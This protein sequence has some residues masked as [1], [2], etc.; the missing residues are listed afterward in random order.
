MP[1]EVVGA[2][3]SE[4]LGAVQDLTTFLSSTQRFGPSLRNLLLTSGVQVPA[5]YG[6]QTPEQLQ[7]VVRDVTAESAEEALEQHEAQESARIQ[8]AA[9]RLLG[10]GVPAAEVARRVAA[11]KERLLSTQARRAASELKKTGSVSRQTRA[12]LDAAKRAYPVANAAVQRAVKVRSVAPVKKVTKKTTKKSKPVPAATALVKQAVPAA[13]QLNVNY[14]RSLGE[15]KAKQVLRQYGKKYGSEALKK[16]APDLNIPGGAGVDAAADLIL[17]G[18]K[19]TAKRVAQAAVSTGAGAAEDFIQQKTGI[20]VR[21]PRKITLKE[22]SKSLSSLVPKNLED[23]IDKGITIGTQYAA[24]AVGAIVAGSAVGSVIPGIGTVVGIGVA[25]AV[26]AL[27]EDFKKLF[28]KERPLDRKCPTKVKCPEPPDMSPVEMLPW[29][30]H[31]RAKVAMTVAQDQRKKYCGKGSGPECDMRLYGLEDRVVRF[32]YPKGK[33]YQDST[34]AFLGLPMVERLQKLYSGA[35]QAYAHYN[36]RPGTR[37]YKT[38]IFEPNNVALSIPMLQARKKVLDEL[39]GRG[40]RLKTLKD[41]QKYRW[42]LSTE[43]EKAAIQ[44]ALDKNKYTESWF[45]TLA[46]MWEGLLARESAEQAARVKEFERQKRLAKDPEI[47][48]K[49]KESTRFLT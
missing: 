32:L 4:G 10:T 35:P 36:R 13:G 26:N 49:L 24:S 48:R 30:A 42:D 16:L 23:A 11:A 19:V 2:G 40:K 38:I 14:L 37:G 29:L 9:T 15:K 44:Y 46:K 20:P 31:E 6:L 1:I 25:L 34:F 41:L 8:A 3:G 33:R 21:L 27:K 18:K 7:R 12:A 17:S 43:L 39:V 45:N 5:A 22:I 47:A 28:G